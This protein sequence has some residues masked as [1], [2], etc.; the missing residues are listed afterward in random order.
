MSI[1]AYVKTEGAVFGSRIRASGLPTDNDAMP[2]ALK[3]S[4]SVALHRSVLLVA[5][6]LCVFLSPALL[7]T[8]AEATSEGTN[9]L[10]IC[11]TLRAHTAASA[12][13][14]GSL[15]IGSRTYPVATGVGAGSG[16]VEVAVGRD[17]CATSSIGLT[18]GR[19]VRYLFCPML[20]GD[21]VCGNLIRP[22]AVDSFA[23]RSD[24][25][26]LTLQRATQ[27]VGLDNP[28]MRVCYAYQ[29]DGG[30]GDLVATAKVPVRD[31]FS[32]REHLTRCGTVKAYVPA[33]ATS[34]GQITIGSAL[35]RIDAGT[36]YTGDP[37]GDRT[38]RT[39]VGQAMCVIS[40]LDT[41]GDIV[42][43][44]TRAMDSNITATAS[45]YTL[46]SASNPG[47]AILSYQS[48]F[49]LRIPA[50]LDATLDLARSTYCFSIAVDANGDM[51]ASAM[52]PCSP[53]VAA[54]GGTATPT[55]TASPPTSASVSPTPT[56]SLTLAPSPSLV[57]AA[58]PTTTPGEPGAPEFL[59]VV[60]VALVAVA[61]L[62][63]YLLRRWLPR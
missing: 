34:S 62:V 42:E 13:A 36:V 46:P 39:T 18:S 63:R 57:A 9:A 17:L 59:V 16:G 52:A 29:V 5:I 28:G 49:E 14:E 48:R 4:S 60:G 55:V 6:T 45:A 35:F 53:G 30:T 2:F 54:G 7:A 22:T 43:Y 12:S 23:M 38:D 27:A 19:L 47:I 21:R 31:N 61:G 33:T 32:D 50:A 56:P 37:A 58:S 8:P 44:L 24:F 11:G 3:Q 10:E 20:S 1:S 25:G 40:T 41:G 15:R 51:T 26:E